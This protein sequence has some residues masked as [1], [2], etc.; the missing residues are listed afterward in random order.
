MQIQLEQKN[1]PSNWNQIRLG[2]IGKVSMCKRIFKHETLSSGAVP[3]YKISTFGKIADSFISEDLFEKYRNKYPYPKKGEILI[4]ASG[5]IGRTVIFDGAKSYFQD[6]N[7]VWISN[8]QAKITNKF[9]GYVY[10]KTRWISTDGGIISRLYNEDLRSIRFSL[11]PLLEQ[12]RIVS[13]LETWDQSIEKLTKK[14][15]IKKQ[16]KKGL[17]QDL[18]TGRKRLGGFVDKWVFITLGDAC[19]QIKTGKLDA[20]AM[21]ENGR[22]RFYTCAKDFYHINDYAFDTE[23]LLISGNGA[24]LGYIHYFKGK[25]NAYQRTYVLYDFTQNILFIKYLL[26][27]FLKTRIQEEVRE[28]NTPYI[29]MDT[30]TDMNLKIPSLREQ[31]LIAEI[32]TIADKEITE[33]EKKLTIIKDQKKYLLNNLITGTIRTP[34]TLSVKS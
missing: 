24:N 22:Y 4:S 8:S 16:I 18:L 10:L 14:I 13:V 31:N 12:N 23:A 25:F 7:I 33:L 21:V 11:P 32:L 15:E 5:T 34:E 1:I 28:G 9:L 20:N 27:L 29:T 6:S 26:D 3:F 17:M 30:L 2:D 19:E